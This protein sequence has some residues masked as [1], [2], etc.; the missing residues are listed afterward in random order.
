MP[1]LNAEGLHLLRAIIDRN[2]AYKKLVAEGDCKSIAADVN[3]YMP[4]T[5]QIAPVDVH[6][7]L[8]GNAEY[9]VEAK[10][11]QV[12]RARIDGMPV[13]Y[14]ARVNSAMKGAAGEGAIQAIVNECNRSDDPKEHVTAADVVAAMDLRVAAKPDKVVEGAADLSGKGGVG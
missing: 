5:M 2:A 4:K 10:N 7:A 8:L 12:L 14:S 1:N 13:L 9:K 6:Y 3:G 11:P